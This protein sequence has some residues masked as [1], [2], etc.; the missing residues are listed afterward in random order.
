MY[1][2]RHISACIICLSVEPDTLQTSYSMS[3]WCAWYF[4]FSPQCTCPWSIALC[5]SLSHTRCV[6]GVSGLCSQSWYLLLTS[7]DLPALPPDHHH[8]H[9]GPTAAP[10]TGTDRWVWTAR[11]AEGVALLRGSR[12]DEWTI[13]I[14]I[15][16]PLLS[17]P[18]PLAFWIKHL[19]SC[20]GSPSPKS[21]GT[22]TLQSIS[23][24][25]EETW[26]TGYAWH[27]GGRNNHVGKPTFSFTYKSTY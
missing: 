17:Y 1:L 14:I 22:W 9:H 16:L 24:V 2:S 3:A 26:E 4:L 25:G 23:S 6:W 13:A 20:H 10:V 5:S 12:I 15:T 19:P 21:G 11:E 7:P 8:H 27:I 18:L